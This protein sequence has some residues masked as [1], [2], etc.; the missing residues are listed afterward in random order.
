MIYFLDQSDLLLLCFE[1]LYLDAFNVNIE[2]FSDSNIVKL[3]FISLVF[4]C[5]SFSIFLI[6]II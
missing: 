5:I 1:F 6:L 3:A 4:L 2:V